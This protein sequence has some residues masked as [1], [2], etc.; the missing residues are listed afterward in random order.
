MLAIDPEK[1][2]LAQTLKVSFVNK[3]GFANAE[4]TGSE[5]HEC[6]LC[7]GTTYLPETDEQGYRRVRPCEGAITL[8]RLDLFNSAYV[9]ARYA[10]AS[11]ESFKPRDQVE[12]G[13]VANLKKY[14]TSFEVGRLGR[15]FFGNAGTGKTHLLIAIIRYL[16]L[17]LAIA[18][19]YVEFTQLLFD[20]R[21]LYSENKPESSLIN[22]LVE[23]PVLFVD[24]LG[25][26]RC[27]DFEIRII[28]EIITRRYNNPALT[29]FFAS[30][31]LPRNF[32][33]SAKPTK[34]ELEKYQGMEFL[35]DRIQFRSASRLHEICQFIHLK[36]DDYRHRLQ[37]LI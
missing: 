6:K 10:T 37:S 3:K 27:N 14:L 32:V 17:D 25:K 21:S 4:A 24:E 30:N 5:A 2:I 33:L 31:Y 11:F 36:G 9:P 1:C 19:R 15:A 23:V 34:K 16:T 29:T 12:R 20:I 18:C 22:P 8:K 35:E 13:Q 7:L 26:G 28:D